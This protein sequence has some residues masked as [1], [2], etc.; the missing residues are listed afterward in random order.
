MVVLIIEE[1][2][3]LASRLTSPR[4]PIALMGFNYNSLAEDGVRQH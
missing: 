1:V 4:L 3:E 2:I